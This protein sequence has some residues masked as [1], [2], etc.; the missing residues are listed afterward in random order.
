MK[1][2]HILT[3]FLLSLTSAFSQG[4]GGVQADI[5]S[6]NIVLTYTSGDLFPTGPVTTIWTDDNGNQGTCSGLCDLS[7]ALGLALVE[8]FNLDSICSS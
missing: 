4:I 7:D 3:I 6:D 5:S 1:Q 8:V 2:I